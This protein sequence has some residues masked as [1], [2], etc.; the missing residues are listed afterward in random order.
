MVPTHP[1][2]RI[3]ER[4]YRAGNRVLNANVMGERGSCCMK[5]NMSK[6]RPGSEL[7]AE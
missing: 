5:S 4:N 3:L 1:V 2:L 6:T 7:S